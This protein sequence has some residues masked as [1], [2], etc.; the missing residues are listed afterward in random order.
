MAVGETERAQGL[1]ESLPQEHRDAA[2]IAALQT[3]LNLAAK[4]NDLGEIGELAGKVEQA[5]NDHQARYDYALALNAHGKREEAAEQLIE[6]VRTDRTWNED[7][8][9]VQLVE[10]FDLWGNTDPATLSGRRALSSILFS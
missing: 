10:F 6:I 1:I 9:R 2:P 8:A 5:P 4:A 3:A 7:G